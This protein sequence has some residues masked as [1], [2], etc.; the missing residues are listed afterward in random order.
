MHWNLFSTFVALMIG[1]YLIWFALIQLGE[2]S[3]R[4]HEYRMAQLQAKKVVP[5]RKDIA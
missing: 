2:W 5:I 3:Q 4:R 1:G